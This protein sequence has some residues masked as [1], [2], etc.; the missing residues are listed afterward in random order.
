LV[1]II[2]EYELSID[3]DLNTLILNE[4]SKLSEQV[5]V[6]KKIVDELLLNP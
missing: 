1:G 4:V 3:P 6:V 5:M 2:G